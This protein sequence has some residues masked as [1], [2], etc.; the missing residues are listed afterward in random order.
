MDTELN[1]NPGVV[2]AIARTLNAPEDGVRLMISLLLGT[3]WFFLP[4]VSALGSGQSV[5]K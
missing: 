2:G 4:F 3:S 1:E 5:G